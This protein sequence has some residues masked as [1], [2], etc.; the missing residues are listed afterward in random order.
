MDQA[1]RSELSQICSGELELEV[2]VIHLF[3]LREEL[4]D[5]RSLLL[6]C[7]QHQDAAQPQAME[8]LG[9]AA[10]TNI[11]GHNYNHIHHRKTTTTTAKQ[12]LTKSEF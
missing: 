9:K 6:E 5:Q 10:D 8:K 3:E 7:E 4:A 12:G 11:A 1:S 2:Q